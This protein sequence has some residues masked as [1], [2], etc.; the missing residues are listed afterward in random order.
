MLQLNGCLQVLL[1]DRLLRMFDSVS[2]LGVVLDSRLTVFSML[3]LCEFRV[4]RGRETDCGHRKLQRSMQSLFFKCYATIL[5]PMIIASGVGQ[6][7]LG[8]GYRQNCYT[9]LF[10]FSISL[11][12]HDY[13]LAFCKVLN[14]V[15]GSNSQSLD[16]PLCG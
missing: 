11:H 3:Y 14:A 4:G 1:E 9:V 12:R 13:V 8:K 16:I 6:K 7:H 5:R 15:D 10:I 2:K